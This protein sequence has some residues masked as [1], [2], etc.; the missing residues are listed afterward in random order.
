LDQDASVKE[1][2]LID[3][4]EQSVELWTGP[5]LP[6]H[7]LTG[8]KALISDLLPGFVLPLSELFG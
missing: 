2:W 3:P 1:V 7:G 4:D 6:D 5:V 8:S